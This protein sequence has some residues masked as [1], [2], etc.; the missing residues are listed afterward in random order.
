MWKLNAIR[1]SVRKGDESVDDS[2]ER[3]GSDDE[4]SRK[5]M[6]QHRYPFH[7]DSNYRKYV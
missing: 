6:G 1:N 4:E 5:D 3:E 7:G 2:Y